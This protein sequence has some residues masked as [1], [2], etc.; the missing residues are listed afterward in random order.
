MGETARLY[1]HHNVMCSD[2]PRERPAP[3]FLETKTSVV[4]IGMCT[5]CAG[6]GF[7]TSATWAWRQPRRL[8]SVTLKAAPLTCLL[9]SRIVG[10]CLA[11]WYYKTQVGTNLYSVFLYQKRLLSLFD[12]D[13]DFCGNNYLWFAI[14]KELQGAAVLLPH[15]PCSMPGRCSTLRVAGPVVQT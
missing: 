10:S 1:L 6:T 13:F 9:L 5:L 15:A 3:C 4:C 12:F 2:A 11:F 14:G 8:L 7:R